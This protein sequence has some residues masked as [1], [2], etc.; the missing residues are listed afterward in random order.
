MDR[1]VTLPATEAECGQDSVS[2]RFLS[3]PQDKCIGDAED[4]GLEARQG[5]LQ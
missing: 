1:Q 3:E 2:E 5:D 4:W